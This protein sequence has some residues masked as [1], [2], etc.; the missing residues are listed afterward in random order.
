MAD[1]IL[2]AIYSTRRLKLRSFCSSLSEALT[3]EDIFSFR[4]LEGHLTL[5]AAILAYCGEHLSCTLL[6]IFLC[7]TALLASRGLVLE[8]SLRV[9][10]LLTC[11]EH[12][13]IAAIS[14]LQSLVLVHGL[15]LPHVFYFC[16]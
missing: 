2:S 5:S 16:P 12:E 6:C 15:S 9:E 3:A 10:L 8:S 4:G 11:G 7:G 1:K 13:I 14:A